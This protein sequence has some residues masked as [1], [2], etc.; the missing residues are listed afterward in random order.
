MGVADATLR[1][2]QF[3]LGCPLPR[4]PHD[5]ITRTPDKVVDEFL[6]LSG[7][8]LCGP[9]E[10]GTLATTSALGMS[11]RCVT[12]CVL[13]R[14]IANPAKMAC[15]Y[16][17]HVSATDMLLPS[18]ATSIPRYLHISPASKTDNGPS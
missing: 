6:N 14:A 16:L 10:P 9:G 11:A 1:T 15:R 4:F 3:R 7:N 13:A 12:V 2:Q 8:F 18:A 5:S 17:L